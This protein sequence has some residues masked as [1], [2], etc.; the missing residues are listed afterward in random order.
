MSDTDAAHSMLMEQFR[1]YADGTLA[2]RQLGEKCR[3]YRDGNQWTEVERKTLQKR[4]QPCITDN[5]IQDKC[6]TLLGMERQMR[7]DP[8]A[9]PRNPDDAD[10]ADAATD[11]LRYVAE[12]CQYKTTTRKPAADNLMVEGL[13]AGQ[14]IVEDKKGSSYPYVC[15]EHIRWDRV[16]YD[17]HCLKDDFTDKTYV[18]YFTWM[19]QDQAKLEWKEKADVIDGSFLGESQEGDRALDDKPRFVLTARK[20]M[21]VQVFTHYYLDSGKWMFARWCRGGFLEGPQPS[22]YK[23]EN[24]EPDCPI[25][26]QALYRDAEGAPYGLVLRYLDLQDEHN[27]RR[28]KML[29][30]LN[31]KRVIVQKGVITNIPEMRGELHKP[32]GVV[33]VAGDIAQLKVEDNL[34][35]AEGQFKLLQQTDAALAATGPNAALLG[36][37]GEISGIAK[38]RDQQAGQ[39]PVAPLFDALDSWELRMYRQTWRRIRQFWTAPMWIRVTD[40]EQRLQF[41]GLNQP[42]TQGEMVAQQAPNDPRFAQLPPEDKQAVIQAIAQHPQAQQPAI[43][44]KTG[45]PL[46]KNDVAVMDVDIII[47]R[48]QD[49]VTAQ[50]EEFSQLMEIAKTRPEIPFDVLIQMSQLRSDTKRLVMERLKGANDPQAQQ[51]AQFQAMMAQLEAVIKQA[52]A[53][54]TMAQADQA[55]AAAAESHVD[56]AVKTATFINSVPEAEK[57]QVTVN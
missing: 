25:E 31:A 5:K 26:M 53:R 27:K 19:D 1:E 50:Q 48:G 38:A 45:K 43:H 17:L 46:R 42:V 13:C 49:V 21:R 54:K 44:G 35:E 34:N 14:V 16:F 55:E 51:Q 30:L 29:H 32:D 11:A 12:S 24:G 36:V 4:K 15:M 8:K 7:T 23:D 33:E 57:T 47:D 22:S 40:D 56:A 52:E 10:S 3:D 9:Y 20:R 37:S 2:A 39:L 41:I 6:D 28:S 18:G